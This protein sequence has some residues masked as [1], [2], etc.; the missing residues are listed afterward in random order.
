MIFATLSEPKL[1]PYF[2]SITFH[3]SAAHPHFSFPANRLT[4]EDRTLERR[5]Q[6]PPAGSLRSRRGLALCRS[7]VGLKGELA[8]LNKTTQKRYPSGPHTLMQV[9]NGGES[10]HSGP[11]TKSSH[12]AKS[13]LK[14]HEHAHTYGVTPCLH[15]TFSQPTLP[16]VSL[17]RLKNHSNHSELIY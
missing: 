5:G 12:P 17:K 3:L 13:T 9:V 10:I 8:I 2:T 16:L 6:T 4:F 11:G 15:I 7:R 1:K 14:Q